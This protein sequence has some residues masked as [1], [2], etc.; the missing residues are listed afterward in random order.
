MRTVQFQPSVLRSLFAR[1]RVATMAQ[2]KE[3]LGS[4]VNMTVLRKLRALGYLTSYS[5]GGKFY[6]LE[7]LVRFDPQGLY[8]VHERCFSRFGSLLN[9]AE[10]FVVHSTGGYYTAELSRELA[11]QTKEALLTLVRRQRV[12][13]MRIDG[14]YLHCAPQPQRRQAQL[15]H[16]EQGLELSG[17]AMTTPAL[18]RSAEAKAALV[19]F[20]STLNERQRRLY[21]GMESLR[22]GYGGDRQSAQLLGLNVHTVARGRREL[23]AGERPEQAVRGT[24]GGR[25]AVEKKRRK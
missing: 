12:V 24:G 7:E 17:A 8:R 10:H 2:L 14:R 22:V 25:V 16:R 20:F 15:M 3:A 23:L 21:A 18:Q 11:V 4:A 9:T 6:T 1:Q 5:H 13:R 19:L